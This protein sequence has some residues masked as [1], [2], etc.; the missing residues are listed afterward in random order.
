MLSEE[1]S[2][3]TVIF[4]TNASNHE[5]RRVFGGIFENGGYNYRFYLLS[6]MNYFDKWLSS[7]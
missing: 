6:L 2:Q 7:S 4:K 5:R 3:T 1:M